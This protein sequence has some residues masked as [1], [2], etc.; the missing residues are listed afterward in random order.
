MFKYQRTLS[1]RIHFD[2]IGLHTGYPVHHELV[3]AP[4]N[5]GIVFRRTDL[6]NFEIEATRAHVARVS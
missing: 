5:T 3:P 4:E 1:N 2:G 6:K